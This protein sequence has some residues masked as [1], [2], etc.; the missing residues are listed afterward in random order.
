MF[1]QLSRLVTLT[2]AYPLLLWGCPRTASLD[3]QAQSNTCV[4]LRISWCLSLSLGLCSPFG[5]QVLPT[6]STSGTLQLPSCPL[7]CEQLMQPF[8]QIFPSRICL[9]RNPE[10]SWERFFPSSSFSF[11]LLFF[12]SLI[13]FY[14][15]HAPC[16]LRLRSRKSILLA[17]HGDCK[18]F[19][20]PLSWK[21]SL[22]PLSPAL[23]LSFPWLIQGIYLSPWPTH[24]LSTHA[25]RHP[26]TQLS[27]VTFSTPSSLTPSPTSTPAT[28]PLGS[29][30]TFIHIT[31][32]C[33]LSEI[34][35]Y[36]FLPGNQLTCFV[37]T[38]F[39]LWVES[40]T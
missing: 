2:C 21:Y 34:S 18:A 10:V 7:L 1:S 23:D 36:C 13:A 3:F 20:F 6:P 5:L 16:T 26:A 22:L 17:P 32:N 9:N 14:L 8:L 19:L 37:A 30:W 4:S 11:H 40:T 31:S 29:P 24:F 12:A 39:T 28:H 33:F 38:Y 25:C 27:Q 35:S 15:S